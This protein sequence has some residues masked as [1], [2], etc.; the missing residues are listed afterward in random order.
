MRNIV[1]PVSTI[2]FLLL[3]CS[4]VAPTP[5]FEATIQASV[6][7]TIAAESLQAPAPTA[8]PSFDENFRILEDQL[9]SLCWIA[10]APTHFDPETG[11]MPTEESI[12]ADLQTLF[13]AGFDGIVTY[14]SD[15]T[16]RH[17]PRIAKEI[18]FEGVIMGIWL[19]ES[20]EEKANAI[21]VVDYVNGYAVGNEGLFFGRYDLETLKAAIK[22]IRAA[23]GKPVTT[24]EVM[25]SYFGDEEIKWLGDWAFPNAHPYWAGIRDP[26]Q[27]AIWTEQQFT[28]LKILYE[29]NPRIVMF[30]EV[31]LPSAG[32]S[33]V[34]EAAQAEYYGLLVDSAVQFVYF[35][36]FDQPWKNSLPI[37]PYWGLFYND[38]SSKPAVD[39]VCR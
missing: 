27:A 9:T 16:F 39:S 31:G 29:E 15:G 11:L 32:E 30:K 28:N 26:E 21:A 23:T 19:P 35:E 2:L 6:R 4:P 25:H 24:T 5:D 33:N 3:G 1:L 8:T 36:A 20:A 13:Q 17:I 12:R 37:E 22:E 14:G 7:Q 18:G 10:Y 38:R 34:S